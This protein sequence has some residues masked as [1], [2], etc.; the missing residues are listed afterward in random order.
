[1]NALPTVQDKID[2][3]RNFLQHLLP[4]GVTPPACLKYDWSN[5]VTIVENWTNLW[6]LDERIS[7]EDRRAQRLLQFEQEEALVL[8]KIMALMEKLAVIYSTYR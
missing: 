2:A 3:C 7:G 1:M 5:H 6:V 4:S 8:P